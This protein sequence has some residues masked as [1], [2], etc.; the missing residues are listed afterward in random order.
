MTNDNMTPMYRAGAHMPGDAEAAIFDAAGGGAV[1]VRVY[2]S[3]NTATTSAAKMNKRYPSL[4]FYARP[5][6]EQHDAAPG[7]LAP[8]THYGTYADRREGAERG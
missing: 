6:P 1:L 7:E 8:V 3:P 5:L 2:A 4:K